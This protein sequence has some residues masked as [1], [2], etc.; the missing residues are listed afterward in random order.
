VGKSARHDRRENVVRLKVEAGVSPARAR[1]ERVL[2]QTLRVLAVAGV[3]LF[4]VGIFVVQ[5]VGARLLLVGLALAGGA[6]VLLAAMG[7]SAQRAIETVRWQDG[8]V[9]IRTVEPGHVGESGQ[10]V[11][12]EVEL[13]PTA[14]VAYEA[15]LNPT[16]RIARLVTTVGPLDVERLVVGTTMRCIIDRAEFPCVLR[17]FPYA[18]PNVP[19]PSG[20]ELGFRRA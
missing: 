14:R 6:V 1:A 13:K 19:L 5:F 17:A 7:W 12:C 11:A 4:I 10:D 16:T 9:T 20:R 18:A 8:T 15:A 2:G 3:A